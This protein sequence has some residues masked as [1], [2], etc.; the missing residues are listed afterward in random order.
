MPTS[1]SNNKPR[2]GITMG[3]PAGIGPEIIA[4]SLNH[5][6]IRRSGQFTIFGDLSAYRKNV[7]SLPRN[8]TFVDLK[9]SPSRKFKAG[10][11]TKR[12]GLASLTYL[13]E[14]V[15]QLKA[16]KIDALVTAPLSKE[17]V[18]LVQRSFLGHTE[19]LAKAFNI[20]QVEMMFVCDQL[21]TVIATRHIP[22]K[23]V[24]RSITRDTV[25]T[26]I[27]LTH[28][29]LKKTFGIKT[30]RLLVCG[31]NPHAGENGNIGLEESEKIVPA[32]KKAK[33]KGMDVAGPFAADTLFSPVTSHRCD[34]II[35]MYHDQG[36]IPVKTLYFRNIVN[37]TIGLPFIRTSPA[38]GTAYDIAGK[39]R[40]DPSSM[41]KAICLA[42]QLAR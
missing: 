30:P 32:I 1:K 26:T 33:R 42:A 29:T 22:L 4:K 3:D 39:N 5:R 9:C 13:Q 35:A 28:Q 41:R 7:F 14:A 18:G 2:I 6:L 21:R 16:K 23:Q 8:C 40:A 31:L 19:Y 25:F 12:S 27:H 10:I 17:A 38:H 15:R 37:L 11:P 20:G 34:A 24:S 36:L